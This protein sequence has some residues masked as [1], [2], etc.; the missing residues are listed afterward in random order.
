[1]KLMVVALA[2]WINQQQEDVIDYLREEVRI[3]K[4][5]Q[6]KRRLRLT[7]E[8]RR[9]L[10]RQ[11]KRIRFDRLKELVGAVTPQTLLAWHRKLIA[12]KYDSSG[13]RRKVGRDRPGARRKMDEADRPESHRLRGRVSLRVP[14]PDPRPLDVV[15]EGVSL[16]P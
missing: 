8:Q 9:R 16:D 2:G 6:G 13:K 10:A 7:D 15:H 12:M 5:L 3:L 11:A 1:M 14:L 4:E